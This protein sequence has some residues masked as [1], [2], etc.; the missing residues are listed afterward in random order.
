MAPVLV[1]LNNIEG[2]SEVA[3]V[4]GCNPSNMFAA[5]YQ[6][7]TDRMLARSLSDRW[8]FCIYGGRQMS[9]RGQMPGGKS[10]IWRGAN[11]RE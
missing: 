5:F 3:D 7:S 9:G 11:I 10:Y 8:A 4:F 2:H 1:T 6:I